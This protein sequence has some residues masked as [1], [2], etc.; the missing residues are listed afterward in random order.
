MELVLWFFIILIVLIIGYFLIRFVIKLY[1]GCNNQ[2]ADKRIQRFF[3]GTASTSIVNDSML[4]ADIENTIKSVI[5]DN[6]YEKLIRLSS[7]Q[8][9]QPLLFFVTMGVVPYLVITV[10][11][12]DDNERAVL[13]NAVCNV[14][15]GYLKMYGYSE[16]L[17]VEWGF[18][19]DIKM[20]YLR[21]GYAITAEQ[22][23]AMNSYL[24]NKRDTL[25]GNY[26]D[27]TDDSEDSLNE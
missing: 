10:P 7:V 15:I 23:R 4:I 21:L 9:N 27:I 19:N 24:E 20:P 2:Q 14:F 8:L 1:T 5:G 11:Y 22:E 16:R 12:E 25:I 17:I 3:N 26:G 6:R 13:E 18:R